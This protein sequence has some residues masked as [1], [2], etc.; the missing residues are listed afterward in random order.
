MKQNK[1]RNM[2]KQPTVKEAPHILGEKR[3]KIALDPISAWELRELDLKL[4]MKRRLHYSTYLAGL[5]VRNMG[6]LALRGGRIARSQKQ[7]TKKKPRRVV[8]CTSRHKEKELSDHFNSLGDQ[9]PSSN[10][11]M[12]VTVVLANPPWE[13][14]PGARLSSKLI[15]EAP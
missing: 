10:V 15:T 4:R 8:C 7:I 1:V 6:D 9:S 12:M 2:N 11:G 3:A 5:S 14:I 13:P